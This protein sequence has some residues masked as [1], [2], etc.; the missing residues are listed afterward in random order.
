MIIFSQLKQG[1]QLTIDF[2]CIISHIWIRNYCPLSTLVGLQTIWAK[3]KVYFDA[4]PL[5]IFASSFYPGSGFFF[6]FLAE[7]SLYLDRL[8]MHLELICLGRLFT[9]L[10]IRLLARITRSISHVWLSVAEESRSLNSHSCQE[11]SCHALSVCRVGS[12]LHTF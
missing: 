1:I 5:W 11:T 3:I 8:L 2:N 9:S 6:I 12:R 4:M 7:T 10:R